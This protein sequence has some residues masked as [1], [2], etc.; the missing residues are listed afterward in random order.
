MTPD[1]MVDPAAQDPQPQEPVVQDPGMESEISQK[2][3]AGTDFAANAKA[4][5]LQLTSFS[6]L[7]QRQS[8]VSPMRAAFEQS[9]MTELPEAPKPF[10]S[11]QTVPDLLYRAPVGAIE[12]T[13]RDIYGAVDFLLGD[14]LPDLPKKRILFEPQTQLGDFAE[15]GFEIA[16]P[17]VGGK[18][19]GGLKLLSP[20]SAL[21]GK[22]PGLAKIPGLYQATGKLGFEAAG[23]AVRKSIYGLTRSNAAAYTAMGIVRDVPIGFILSKNGAGL[24]T[25]L[26][27]SGPEGLKQIG[28][29]L[30][31]SE[32]DSELEKRLKGTLEQLGFGA[33]A[34]LLGAWI[35]SVYRG[36]LYEQAIRRRAEGPVPL[37]RTPK[38]IRERLGIE[39]SANEFADAIERAQNDPEQLAYWKSVQDDLEA[40]AAEQ[41]AFWRE[42]TE[43]GFIAPR[44]FGISEKRAKLLEYLADANR[45]TMKEGE[46][47][48]AAADSGLEAKGLSRRALLEQMADQ[49]WAKLNEEELRRVA[50]DM[51]LEEKG[52]SREDLLDKMAVQTRHVLDQ[53]PVAR[54]ASQKL[55]KDLPA[56][57][58]RVRITDAMV[59]AEQGALS[60]E[61]AS[62]LTQA[63]PGQIAR[64]GVPRAR[65]P[66]VAL[67][68]DQYLDFARDW[69]PADAQRVR[70]RMPDGSR[71]DLAFESRVDNA[72]WAATAREHPLKAKAQADLK[73]LGIT[74]EQIAET[75]AK[76]K[77]S[78]KAA[79]AQ[80]V[81]V[82]NVS[83]SMVRVPSSGL[84][85]GIRTKASMPE[86]LREAEGT[87]ISLN[88]A[89]IQAAIARG[90]SGAAA[91]RRVAEA[92]G[93]DPAFAAYVEGIGQRLF[94]D[95]VFTKA[96]GEGGRYIP[97]ATAAGQDLIELGENLR[98]G[99][100]VAAEEIAHKLVNHLSPEEWASV[101]SAWKDA[102]EAGEVG[103]R[104]SNAEEFFAHAVTDEALSG[105][106]RFQ[107]IQAG[108]LKG[109]AASI[110]DSMRDLWVRAK[111]WLG[112]NRTQ[113]LANDFLRGRRAEALRTDVTA[114]PRFAEPT[115]ERLQ[116]AIFGNEKMAAWE[117][118]AKA[119]GQ[120]D[121]LLSEEKQ[122]KFHGMLQRLG[123]GLADTEGR[124]GV[125]DALRVVN[126]IRAVAIENGTW[127]AEVVHKE[128]W[129]KSVA[130]ELG[131][132]LGRRNFSTILK[133]VGKAP[134]AMRKA[135]A[136]IHALATFLKGEAEKA[137]KLQ[138]ALYAKPAPARS[139]I[140]KAEVLERLEWVDQAAKVVD[141]GLAEPGRL[142]AFTKVSPVL[143]EAG[144][145][146]VD[147]LLAS[148]SGGRKL[149]QLTPA[150]SAEVAA[151]LDNSV[152]VREL[153]SDTEA[154]NAWVQQ[155]GGEKGIDNALEAH[156]QSRAM[157]MTQA[158]RVAR[159]RDLVNETKGPRG[160]DFITSLF[161]KNILSGL[162]TISSAV[163]SSGSM[164]IASPGRHWL[165]SGVGYVFNSLRGD[166]ALMAKYA[167]AMRE[168]E[169]AMGA[170]FDTDLWAESSR[171]ARRAYQAGQGQL[172]G[173][174][175]LRYNLGR[176]NEALN[177]EDFRRWLE[178]R[179]ALAPE[180]AKVVYD[181]DGPI[182]QGILWLFSK[183]SAGEGLNWMDK[184]S[185]V[186]TRPLVA[187]DELVRQVTSRAA[188]RGILKE[189]AMR[190]YPGE[191]WKWGDDV[192]RKMD[193]LI[194]QEGRLLTKQRIGMDAEK[195]A[196]GHGLDEPSTAL[197]KERYMEQRSAD[198]ET[199]QLLNYSDFV[200]Y[201]A[202]EAA[203]TLPMKRGGFSDTVR[204]LVD[205]HGWPRLFVPFIASPSSILRTVGQHF[206]FPSI[207][208]A[209]ALRRAGITAEKFPELV[210][211]ERRIAL[212]LLS[213]EPRVRAE[214]IGRLSAGFMFATGFGV[215]AGKE[216]AEGM[217]LI[218]GALS[219]VK[220][221]RELQEMRGLQAYSIYVPGIGYVSYERL[222]PFATVIGTVADFINYGK[223]HPETETDDLAQ[224]GSALIGAFAHDIANKSW[225]M[226]VSQLFEAVTSGDQSHAVWQRLA[227]S[228]LTSL[229]IPNLVVQQ[230]GALGGDSALREVHT[231]LLDD[232]KRKLP[233]FSEMLPPHRNLLGEPVPRT[234]FLDGGFVL[235]FAQREVSDDLVARELGRL[236][237]SFG[238]MGPN[239]KDL[240]MDLRDVYSP[241]GRQAYDRLGENLSNVRLNGQ[242]LRE[243]LRSYFTSARYRG[244]ESEAAAR[245]PGTSDPRE[246][247]VRQIFEM[248]RAAA[249]QKT[250]PEFPALQRR[251]AE[252]SRPTFSL[253]L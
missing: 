64:T 232:A 98:R 182:A 251:R 109:L 96:A 110:W 31:T 80:T 200:Q 11:W 52:L 203:A 151:A 56:V 42:R 162:R 173:N 193:L 178:Q 61:A 103:Y 226:G 111:G 213:E 252:L 28:E 152:P 225:L 17:G 143:D 78:V 51:G 67:S 129:V 30:A 236:G 121:P 219:S 74:E 46:L 145:K 164:T 222:D 19:K 105:F 248:Y 113:A 230:G 149:P 75:A 171:A 10:A 126:Q 253:A 125:R 1:P 205:E 167:S 43:E 122:V 181:P 115:W 9:R 128:E 242:T 69:K 7:E 234:K 97:R 76:L 159:L 147:D 191:P 91:F 217:P 220:A 184:L 135:G 34:G 215:L 210:K 175:T 45:F 157:D 156:A 174:D 196:K 66:E 132:M 71:P 243:A 38:D 158:E 99:N 62:A 131:A 24:S 148:Y 237:H 142:L 81:K 221:I 177:P 83:R 238:S 94:S 37:N 223:M 124:V 211:N 101:Q 13:A 35:R 70:Y 55:A 48:A 160:W 241:G 82:G 33:G 190:L 249:Y 102:V 21:I 119:Q 59:E 26:A 163:L 198:P 40:T 77:Q 224:K 195:I 183:N 36:T 16:G 214:A 100:E 127:P 108:G 88:P 107:S 144:V 32:S 47:R 104:Y 95:V 133:E 118:E 85:Q 44:Q 209:Q 146:V 240:G 197:F 58:A 92:S 2:K 246:Q 65:T 22:T 29:V 247:E 60:T 169:G 89:D 123:Q 206:D 170:F 23:E 5:G 179:Q 141:A 136:Q 229:A 39:R 137:W 153:A 4:L 245:S 140:D 6:D 201:R 176:S 231:W 185:R 194:D 165:G 228:T 207:W 53:E 79:E 155:R 12:S 168:A 93:A 49:N 150:Q 68:A 166:T 73:A 227:S 134:E 86:V 54:Y 180:A 244:L 90:E 218:T 188:L 187:G 239:R 172:T 14:S 189:E 84:E 212:E 186:S 202:N 27:S 117:A 106:S 250:E 63:E 57:T 18:L 192:A 120:V 3:R 112:V 154:F 138:E 72:V 235:P 8:P 25:W 20:V 161:V 130:V 41:H 199:A 204:R 114:A 116:K 139:L 216:I 87:T 50:S 15:L 233:Y 208:R